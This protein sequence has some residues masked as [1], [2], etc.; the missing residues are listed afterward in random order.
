MAISFKSTTQFKIERLE[1]I[2]SSNQR[3]SIDA[4]F[5]ELNLYDNLFTPCVSGN[6]L[7]TDTLALVDQLK[8]NGDEKIYIRISKDEDQEDFRYEK[9]FVI[10][11]LTNKTNLNMTSTAYVLNFVS[12]EFL[13]SL[14]KK[15]NQNYVGTFTDIVYQILTDTNY[16]GVAEE[17]P[18]N[19]ESGV[20][21][22]FQ[23]EG[24]Q[25]LIFP[26]LTP[27]DAINFA[28]QKAFAQNNPDFLFF[29]THKT[30]YN[31]LPLTYLLQQQNVFEINFKPKNLSN[32]ANAN[33][34]EFLGARD[35]KVLSQFSVLDGVQGGIFA[36][37][38]VGFDTLTKTTKITTI[39]SNKNLSDENNKG[40]N[41]MTNSRVVSYPF[42]LPRTTVEYI[43]D[44]DPE[45]QNIMDHSENY[46]FQR[47]AIFT[48]LMQQR[49]QLVMPGNFELFSSRNIYL[50]V[51]KFSTQLGE[52]ALDRFLSGKYIITGARHIVKPNRHETIVEVCAAQLLGLK[53][54]QLGAE[55]FTQFYSEQELQ[56]LQL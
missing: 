8:L 25:N 1:L 23:S 54:N 3:I 32:T 36:G 46:V 22:F 50:K 14:Q 48:N 45:K 42:A 24:L 37:R 15:V 19:G 38:F 43:K 44:N 4:L 56:D 34:D 30:G 53:N 27:F 20:G 13:L 7:I 39:V 2:I 33:E 11:S 55:D 10:Y 26:T 18:Q 28:S 41:Q 21:V 31:F 35:L 40:F 49:L 9:E 29:E 52:D 6:I 17:P 47:K 16:L 51:P 5:S 12:K